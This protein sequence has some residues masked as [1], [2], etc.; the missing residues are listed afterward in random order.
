MARAIW[1]ATLEIAEIEIPVKLYA[2]ARDKKIHFRLLH[3]KDHVPVKQRMVRRSDGEVVP[4][5][6]I[7]KGVEV[8]PGVFVVLEPEELEKFAPKASRSIEVTR[9]VPRGAVAHQWFDRPYFLGPDGAKQDYFALVAALEKRGVLGIARWIMRGSGYVGALGTKDGALSLVTLRHAEEV[10]TLP[11]FDQAPT[12]KLDEREAK[13][14]RQLV[15]TLAGD[16][17]P[18]EFEDDYRARL[19]QLIETK[20]RGG[21]IQL[22]RFRPKKTTGS[23]ADALRQSVAKAKEKRVA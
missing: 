4:S 19:S 7:V 13:L 3:A 2:A 14:A 22:E 6:Q 16:F 8:E 1:K 5:D 23:L 20:A 11:A 21:S 17:D 15:E 9:F 10:V 12:R 18:T